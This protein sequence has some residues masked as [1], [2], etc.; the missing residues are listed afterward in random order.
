ME[1]MVIDNTAVFTDR[2]NLKV[3]PEMRQEL[4]R[5]AA[6]IGV[7]TSDVARWILVVGIESFNNREARTGNGDQ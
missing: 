6:A 5:M 7:S 3:Q 1:T 4:D 2:L